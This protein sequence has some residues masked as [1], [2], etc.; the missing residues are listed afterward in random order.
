MGVGWRWCLAL[1]VHITELRVGEVVKAKTV[2]ILT[3]PIS[4][5]RNNPEVVIVRHGAGGLLEIW[6]G[7]VIG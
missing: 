5:S 4:K 1:F 7:W 3:V 2:R 6:E